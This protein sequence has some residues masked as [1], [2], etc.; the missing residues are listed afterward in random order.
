MEIQGCNE[1]IVWELSIVVQWLSRLGDF[2]QACE[3]FVKN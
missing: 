1:F 2:L 3:Q